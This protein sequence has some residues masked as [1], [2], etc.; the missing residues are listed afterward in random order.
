MASVCSSRRG[1]GGGVFSLKGSVA[2]AIGLCSTVFL[3]TT[4]WSASCFD[5]AWRRG[6]PFDYYAAETRVDSGTYRGGLLHLVEKVHFGDDVRNLVKGSS[7]RLPGDILFVLNT[8]PNHPGALDAYSRYEKRYRSSQTF[9]ENRDNERPL[10][11]AECFFERAERI[12]PANP[13]TRFVW[14]LHYYRNGQLDRSRTLMESALELRPGYVEAHYNLGLVAVSQGM[15]E[16][17]R[18]HAKIAY[19]AGYPLQGL[20]RRISELEGQ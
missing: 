20:R 7:S 10:Y 1:V 4:A 11:E 9:R 19:D 13:Q 6:K 17:A 12:F 5:L 3:S 16:D 8:I 14:G 2:G 18:R 15:L